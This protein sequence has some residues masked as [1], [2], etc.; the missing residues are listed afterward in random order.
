[1]P[2]AAQDFLTRAALDHERKTFDTAI[3]EAENESKLAAKKGIKTITLEG[4]AR[5]V[6]I[7]AVYEMV[8]GRLKKHSPE[9]VDALRAKFFRN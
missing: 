4:K 3:K 2:K 9:N 1:M 8:W 7:S 5:D 6:Y